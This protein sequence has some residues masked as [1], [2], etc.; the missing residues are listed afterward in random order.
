MFSVLR[1]IRPITLAAPS[2]A[3]SSTAR[4]ASD[5]A[6][7]T[8]VGNVTKEPEAR[9]SK[10]DKQY[11]VYTVVTNGLNINGQGE[12]EY[13]PTFHRVLC[14]QPSAFETVS[15]LKKGSKVFVQA[16]FIV[17]DPAPDADASTPQG[18]RQI[19]LTHDYIKVL[20]SPKPRDF[21]STSGN[22]TETFS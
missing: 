10:A 13:T 18:Q 1:A 11:Y 19:M 16:D 3:F 2:R 22:E 20:Y 14:F 6:K 17:K 8:L 9:Q 12:R 4:K 21:E 15:R 7:L 5:V